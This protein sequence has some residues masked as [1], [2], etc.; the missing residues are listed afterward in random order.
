MPLRDDHDA[1][2]ARADALQAELDRERAEHA[3]QTERIAELERELAA[4]RQRL[5]RAEEALGDI[6]PRKRVD[7]DRLPSGRRAD[8]E[9]HASVVKPLS[10]VAAVLVIGV[11]LSLCARRRGDDAVKAIDPP[12]PQPPFV[13]DVLVR[14]GLAQV[15]DDTLAVQEIAVDY[16]APDGTLDVTHGRI[17]IA[18]AKRPPPKP[19]DDPSRPTGAPGPD[20]TDRMVAMM[21]ADCPQPT[22][23]PHTG[24]E[25]SSGSCMSFGDLARG[26]PVCSPGS[27][28]ARARADGAPDGL[29][30]VHAQWTFALRAHGRAWQ[31]TYSIS[32]RARGV[33]FSRT[34]DDGDCTPPPVEK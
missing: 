32:D 9:A 6:K 29:A 11:A 12:R 18:T 2:L 22:W 28:V 10:V 25:R 33:D 20:E 1:A 3:D 34:Y 5:E 4:A 19:P 13:A 8:N 26:A 15:T 17:R 31:W 23:S 14:E 30:R 24:W 16:V 21:M 27:I 7:A